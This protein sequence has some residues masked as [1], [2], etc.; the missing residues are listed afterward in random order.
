MYSSMPSEF[1]RKFSYEL[2]RFMDYRL[3]G[4][5]RWGHL[6]SF[7]FVLD[8]TLPGDRFLSA[9]QS[10]FLLTHDR[11]ASKLL[12]TLYRKLEHCWII[13][14]EIIRQLNKHTIWLRME[15]AL[16]IANLKTASVVYCFAWAKIQFFFE[17]GFVILW[18]KLTTWPTNKTRLYRYFIGRWIFFFFHV[19]LPFQ[20][21]RLLFAS[22][23]IMIMNGFN[24]PICTFQFVNRNSLWTRQFPSAKSSLRLNIN[25]TI[26]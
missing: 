26:L 15:I 7:P 6:L 12:S 1:R 8:S 9:I 13:I 18:G 11:Y 16:K 10:P 3:A 22:I 4:D 19:W 20:C 17:L 25:K 5:E 24:Q 14:V 2:T 21:F 23:I